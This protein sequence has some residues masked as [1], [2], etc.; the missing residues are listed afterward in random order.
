MS[1]GRRHTEAVERLRIGSR[2]LGRPCW[3]CGQAIDYDLVWPD[4]RSFS[5]DHIKPRS[6]RPDLEHEPTNHAP[7]HLGCNSSRQDS[8]ARPGLGGTSRNW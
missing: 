8:A 6:A 7:A 2:S 4:P 3:L 5:L 1:R